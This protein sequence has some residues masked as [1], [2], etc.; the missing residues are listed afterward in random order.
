MNQVI[1]NKTPW[2]KKQHYILLLDDDTFI[3]ATV[4][5]KK[6]MEVLVRVMEEIWASSEY[7]A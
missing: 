7:C 5:A 3:S 2:P 6:N 1:E 4:K